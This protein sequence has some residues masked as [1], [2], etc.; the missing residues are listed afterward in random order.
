[1]I[2]REYPLSPLPE[3]PCEHG[4]AEGVVELVRAG[5]KEVFAF[6]VQPLAGREAVRARE[7]RGASGERAPELVELLLEGRVRLRVAPA[8]FELVERRNQGLGD[9]APAVGPEQARGRT[10]RAAATKARTLS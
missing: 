9:V 10:H 5:V 8:A 6:Q 2:E 3:S 7:R 4:L 1:V